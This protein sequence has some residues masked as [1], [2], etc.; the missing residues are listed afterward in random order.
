MKTFVFDIGETLVRDDRYWGSWADWLGTP[1]HTLSALVG[2][3]TAQGLDNSEALKLVRPG[4]DIPAEYA[5]R[6][7]AGWGE[8]LDESDLY[9]DVRPALARLQALGMRVVVAGNQT[10]RAG[11]LLRALDLPADLVA[12]SEGWGCAKPSAEFFARVLDA[13]GA[14]ARD[15]VYVGDHPA[16]DT[17]PAADAGLRTAHL[18]RGPWGHLWANDPRVREKADWVVESLVELAAMVEE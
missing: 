2:A 1:R 10:A 9:E 14:P 16:N 7:A 15:T 12:T 18:R 8:Y 13:S 17:F 4:I 3:V 11:E 5:A 6:E